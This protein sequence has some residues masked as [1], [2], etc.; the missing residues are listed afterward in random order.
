[1]VFHKHYLPKA[2]FSELHFHLD[3]ERLSKNDLMYFQLLIIR[4][5]HLN[6]CFLIFQRQKVIFYHHFSNFINFTSSFDQY[7]IHLHLLYYYLDAQYCVMLMILNEISLLHFALSLHFS[8]AYQK[9]Q[10]QESSIMIDLSQV[11]KSPDYLNDLKRIM[12]VQH[13][14]KF[15]FD[16]DSWLIQFLYFQWMNFMMLILY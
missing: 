1:M 13:Y 7:F 11:K 8:N 15:Q 10:N 4:Y 9:I 3:Q 16:F 5:F 14:F 6:L 2:T 12:M